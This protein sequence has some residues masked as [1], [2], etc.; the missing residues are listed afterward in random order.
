MAEEK[1]QKITLKVKNNS[2]YSRISKFLIILVLFV[3]AGGIVGSGVIEIFLVIF[4]KEPSNISTVQELNGKWNLWNNYIN[5]KNDNYYFRSNGNMNIYKI[6]KYNK[7]QNFKY[8]GGPVGSGLNRYFIDSTNNLWFLFDNGDLYKSTNGQLQKISLGTWGDVQDVIFDK[9][10]NAYILINSINDNRNHIYYVA[11]NN[12]NSKELN[13]TSDITNKSIG[14]IKVFNNKL[15][16][17]TLTDNKIYYFDNGD[18]VPNLFY[19]FDNKINMKI[20]IMSILNNQIF[21]VGQE[22]IKNSTIVNFY[23]LSDNKKIIVLNKIS[24]NN[25]N[26]YNWKIDAR[27][28]IYFIKNGEIRV[29]NIISNQKLICGLNNK[30]LNLNISIFNINLLNNNLLFYANQKFYFIKNYLSNLSNFIKKY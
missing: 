19:S 22:N 1:K 6:N 16:F 10:N 8:S 18:S 24:Y 13:I 12:L 25:F 3:F 21:L 28:N 17:L 20:E 15:F 9:E 2:F 23:Y 7:I 4:P 14:F 11:N 5:F 26:Y 27:M 29:F 30:K